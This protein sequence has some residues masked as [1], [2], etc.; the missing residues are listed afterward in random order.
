MNFESKLEDTH[1]R[2]LKN[3]DIAFN[4]V[5]AN[6]SYKPNFFFNFDMS[7]KKFSLYLRQYYLF[8]CLDFDQ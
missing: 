4:I 1:S 2:H 8:Y 3:Y 6:I 5:E 7:N